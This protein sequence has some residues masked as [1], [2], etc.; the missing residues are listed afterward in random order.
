MAEIKVTPSEVRNKANELRSLNTQ[1]K[2][3]VEALVNS[4]TS[5]TGMWE[6][7]S[8]AAFHTA[9]NNDRTQMDNFHTTIE[10]YAT[11]L[12]NIATEYEN[13]EALNVQIASNRSYS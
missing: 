12:D 11:A 2:S 3:K 1:F 6:G 5:L 9:F 7:D 10:Q 8:K 13:K 4:E